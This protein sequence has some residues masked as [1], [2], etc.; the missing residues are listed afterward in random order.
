MNPLERQETPPDFQALR[1]ES[2]RLG[3]ITIKFPDLRDAAEMFF[4][5]IP[6]CISEAEQKYP[7][8]HEAL[9]YLVALLYRYFLGDEYYPP[10]YYPD[11]LPIE[12]QPHN[13]AKKYAAAKMLRFIRSNY[14]EAFENNQ[15][16]AS[17]P[18]I[19]FFTDWEASAIRVGEKGHPDLR[20]N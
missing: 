10:E 13:G 7:D 16:L 1:M 17:S 11:V 19:K 5:D 12:K 14:P 3:E 18:N 15:H 4:Q 20:G 2:L 8:P 9:C 6:Q